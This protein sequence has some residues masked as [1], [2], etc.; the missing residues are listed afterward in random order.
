MVGVCSPDSGLVVR[1]RVANL[2][3]TM[4]SC[5]ICSVMAGMMR[6]RRVAW[7]SRMLKLTTSL[8]DDRRARVYSAL[9]FFVSPARHMVWGRE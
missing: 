4:S 5:V 1:A 9:A 8:V 6:E 7:L 3:S 2:L